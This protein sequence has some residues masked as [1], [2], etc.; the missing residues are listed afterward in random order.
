MGGELPGKDCADAESVMRPYY[1]LNVSGIVSRVAREGLAFHALCGYLIIEYIRPQEIFSGLSVVPWGAIF[2]A[3][4]VLGAIQD[5]RVTYISHPASKWIVAYLFLIGVSSLYAVY[6]DVSRENW[7]QYYNWVILYFLIIC[8]VNTKPRLF[9]FLLIMLFAAFKISLSLALSFASRGFSFTRWGLVGPSGYFQNSGELAILMVILFSFSAALFPVLSNDASRLKRY[10]LLLAPIT[11]A[12]TV[13]GSSS[14]GGQIALLASCGALYF[15]R[16]FKL[17]Y[18]LGLLVIA[19][20]ALV[21]LPDAQIERFREI[22]SDRTSLQR[23]AYWEKGVEMIEDRPLLGVGYF[24]FAKVFEERY[25]ELLYYEHAELPHNIFIQA[26]TDCGILGLVVYMILLS[27][28][29]RNIL[30]KSPQHPAANDAVFTALG[31]GFNAALTGFI[32]AGQFVS[33]VYYPFMWIHLALTI[34][35]ARVRSKFV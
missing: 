7:F 15:R 24:N 10:I 11:A 17:K 12:L 2:I 31:V 5:P 9:V 6:P 32:V 23:I 18:I 3:L 28:G 26:G 4:A 29:Y 27:Y 19:A 1:Q 13:I 22:G 8:I 14:R 35:Y 21:V 16:I 34:C 25:P 30:I 33:V 20:F